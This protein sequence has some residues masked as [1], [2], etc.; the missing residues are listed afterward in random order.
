M[1]EE[2]KSRRSHTR[3]WI[4]AGICVIL[5]AATVA[6][7]WYL[8]SPAFEDLI[9]RKI[10]A[11]LE[12]ATGSRVELRAFHWNLAKLEFTADDVTVHGREGPDQV[13]YM[14]AD[15]AIVRLRII[16]VLQTRVHL[17]YVGLERP[18][19]HVIVYPDGTTNAPEPKANHSNANPVQQIVDLAITR[20][21]LHNGTLL[22]NDREIP[23]DFSADDVDADMTYDRRDRRYDGTLHIGRIDAKYHD[24]RDVPAQA[25]MEF[26][27]WQ[28]TAQIKALKLTSEKSSL[29]AQGKLTHYE[30]PRIEFTYNMTLD[31]GQLGAITRTYDLR[32]GTLTASGSGSYSETARASRGKLAIRGFEYL[33]EGVVLHSVNVAADYSLDKSRLALTRIAGRL[34]G[35]EITGEAII[36]NL[37]ASSSRPVAART[38]SKSIRASREHPTKA[39]G[40]SRAANTATISGPGPQHGT[41]RL[42]VSG[43]SLAELARAISTRSLPFVSLNPAGMVGGTI[44]LAWTR[45][46]SEAQGELA[47]DIVPLAQPIGAELPMSGDLRGHWYLRPQVMDI[48]TFDLKTPHTD[49]S[50]AG[51]LGT[52]SENLKVAFAATSLKELEPFVL[53]LGYAPSPIELDGAAT[54]TGI[55]S[56]RLSDSRVDGHVQASNFTYNYTPS[57]KAPE[58]P[59]NPPSKQGFSLR[60]PPA[61][62]SEAWPSHPPSRRIHIDQFS[63]DVQYSLSK[64]ALHHAVIQ[65]GNARLN[66]DWTA[67]L[68]KGSFTDDSPFQL[69]AAVQNADVAELQHAVGVDYPVTGKLNATVE[70]MGTEANPQGRG[71]F[72]LTA[73]EVYGRPV[74]SGGA[75]LAFANHELQF[76]HIHLQAAGGVIAG[77]A[78]YNFTSEGLQFDLNGVSLDLAQIPE[79]QNAHLQTAGIVRFEAKGAGTT[80]EPVIN[81]HLQ[82]NNL[83]LNGESVGG[84]TADA[85][86]RGRQLQLT[87]RSN[88]PKASFSLDGNVELRGDMPGSMTMQFSDLDITPFLRG[89]VKGK[90]TGHPAVAGRAT[91]RGPLKQPRLLSGEFK[92][93][94]FSVEVEKIRIASD[95]PI[96][97][98]LDQGVVAV[99]HCALVSEDSRLALTGTLSFK[100]DR[101]LNL[102]ADGNVNLKLVHTLDPDIT[103]YGALTMGITVTGEA[104]KPL[105]DGRIQIEHAGLSMIDLPAGLGDVNGSFVFNQDRLEV[106]HLTARTGGGLMTFGG[107]VTYGRIVGFDLTTKGNDIRFR[108][109]GISVT[110]DQSL[111]LSGNLQ[112]S[113]LTGDVT[114]TRFAQIPSTDLALALAQVGPPSPVANPKSPLNGLR[115]DVRILSAPELTVQTTLAKLSGGVDLRL[116][117][118]A[119][120]PVLLGRINIAEG[121]LKIQGTKYHL[122]RGDITFIDPVRI[123]PVLDVEATT[124]VRDY[125]ITIGLHGTLE[126]LTTTYRSDPPLSSEDIVALLAFGRTQ[127]DTTASATPQL[128]FAE[129]ASNAVLGQALNQ[130]VSNRMSRLFGVSSIR[131]NPAV[132]GPDNNPNARLTVEQQVTNNVTLTYIT[133]LTRAAQ[134]VIQFEYNINSE[135]SLQGIRDENGVVSIDLLVRKRKR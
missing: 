101:R 83:A 86:T 133:N 71:Q 25:E 96:E 97:L 37:L 50:A 119:A 3:V 43:V 121:D 30:N 5:L 51:T 64:V 38:P 82:V 98:R 14:H 91:L 122:E 107:F 10:I 127:Y 94:Q 135:Y 23:L 103:S 19:I 28:D 90:I 31:I 16:S 27:L 65:E 99:Q 128:G 2:S 13:P 109:A 131:I 89:E 88:F 34:L 112:S 8:R 92:I 75:D 70:A 84:V 66:V 39:G 134:Q 72:I 74:K 17:K 93:D 85:V 80:Q 81:A 123:D 78:A 21:D 63:A 113:S 118:T 48:T 62:P 44:D 52:T 26:A 76:G 120:R 18:V 111:H 22:L 35:G 79:L 116:R 57:R 114:V 9:R 124:R 132:G 12:N 53:A 59:A 6:I 15:R 115:L 36:D 87:A 42:R 58:H 68:E 32:A 4:G 102:R 54:F 110:S 1:P 106:E 125:D 126:R 95:G 49:L 61:H 60:T 29:E 7:V 46:L 117:G 67:G 45:A 69:H 104:A 130:S 41:A 47:L 100:D 108:Y 24:L 20:A 40:E 77:A 33:Q 55:V 56:G 105:I 129:S 73:A 11:A